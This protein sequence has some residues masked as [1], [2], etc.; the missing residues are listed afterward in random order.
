MS[1]S[2]A[3]ALLCLQTCVVPTSK[4]PV[5]GGIAPL[6]RSA[7]GAWTPGASEGCTRAPHGCQA[8]SKAIVPGCTGVVQFLVAH[9]RGVCVFN[10]LCDRCCCFAG[11]W[12][13]VHT[14]FTTCTSIAVWEERPVL[15]AAWAGD[16]AC[17]RCVHATEST[18]TCC[19]PWVVLQQQT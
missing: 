12:H 19:L 3:C 1:R 2:G 7:A 13:N 8:V 4:R 5:T 11:V 10:L 15:L 16:P 14:W 17:G 6:L 9:V 18:W